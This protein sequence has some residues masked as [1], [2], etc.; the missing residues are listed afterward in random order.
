L[1]DNIKI[2]LKEIGQEGTD[3]ALAQERDQWRV[4]RDMVMNLWV[5]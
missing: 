3:W 2:Y 1:E 5:P 4:L